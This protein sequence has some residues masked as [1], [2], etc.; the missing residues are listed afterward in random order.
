MVVPFAEATTAV[1]VPGIGVDVHV[2]ESGESV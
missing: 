2:L 1:G